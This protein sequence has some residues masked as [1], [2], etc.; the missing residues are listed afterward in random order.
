MIRELTREDF[1]KAV[2]NPYYKDLM[3]TIT[4]DIPKEDLETYSKLA[5]LSD[6][7]VERL[8]S[9]YLSDFAEEIRE[10]D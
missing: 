6:S 5:K 3:T 7:P 4:L 1:K 2:R 9:G 10:D 8:M